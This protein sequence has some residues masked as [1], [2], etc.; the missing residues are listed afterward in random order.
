M[1]AEYQKF[2]HWSI[3]RVLNWIEK[4]GSGERLPQLTWPSP[5]TLKTLTIWEVSWELPE[6]KYEP[7]ESYVARKGDPALNGDS[8][9]HGPNNVKLILLQ[10]QNQG[11]VIWT[12]RKKLLQQAVQGRT[13]DDGRDPFCTEAIER[14]RGQLVESLGI[15][16]NCPLPL[17]Q[18]MQQLIAKSSRIT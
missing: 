12:K 5:E 2:L 16:E 6:E 8:V 7:Y 11:Q 17:S 15:F 9:R 3:G 1:H 18:T 13:I 10:N 14:R 4:H